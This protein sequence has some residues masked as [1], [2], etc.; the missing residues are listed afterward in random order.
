MPIRPDLLNK[1]PMRR[2]FLLLLPLACGCAAHTDGAVI[3]AG[4]D[5][6]AAGLA[7]A[8]AEPNDRWQVVEQK[9]AKGI[10]KD[11]V[12][13]VVIPRD[14]FELN[15][16]DLGPVPAAAGIESSF[17]F[18]LCPCG[19]TSVIGQFVL[20]E[21][22]INDVID[23]LRAAHVKVASVAAMM[24]NAQPRLYVLRFHGEGDVDK[25]ATTLNS[26]LEWTGR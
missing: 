18:F 10:R 19:K 20:Q 6:V 26:A 16:L 3:K 21:H 4:V 17:H 11:D 25:L 12:Y 24:L 7:V 13:T 5:Q 23:E 2:L 9:L 14:D 22:E 1:S 15:H 8:T